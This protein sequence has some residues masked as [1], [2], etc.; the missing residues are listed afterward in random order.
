MATN[1]LSH[2]KNC[3]IRKF[4]HKYIMKQLTSYSS[5]VRRK[6]KFYYHKGTIIEF[7]RIY[8]GTELK[9]RIHLQSYQ[10]ILLYFGV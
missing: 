1:V 7:F 8:S 5:F 4:R 3:P 10:K 2:T 9:N 6:D